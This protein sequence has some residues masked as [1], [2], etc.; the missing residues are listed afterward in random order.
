MQLTRVKAAQR[1]EL[2]NFVLTVEIDLIKQLPFSPDIPDVSQE[3]RKQG[4]KIWPEKLTVTA[5]KSK[6]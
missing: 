4:V 2:C 6:S 5:A 1:L 3:I